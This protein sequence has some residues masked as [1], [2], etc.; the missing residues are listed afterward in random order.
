MYEQ[1]H[2]LISLRFLQFLNESEL[3]LVLLPFIVTVDKREQSQ[4]ALLYIPD[5]S[6]GIEISVNAVQFSNIFSEIFSA[7]PFSKVTSVKFVQLLK[8]LHLM[9]FIEAGKIIPVKL[10]HPEN[11]YLPILSSFDGKVISVKPLHPKNANSD[12]SIN[13]SGNIAVLS[14]LQD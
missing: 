12:I 6:S 2:P 14:F 5:T 3:I 13:V 9:F 4:N 7:Y 1:L 11:A 8:M 10:L